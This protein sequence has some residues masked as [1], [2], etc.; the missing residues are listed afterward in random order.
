MAF[1]GLGSLVTFLIFNLRSQLRS[2]IVGVVGRFEF[3]L[4][5]HS[6]EEFLGMR[7]DLSSVSGSNQF[8]YFFPVFAVNL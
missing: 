6:E 3:K 7:S 5:F 8:L 2:G 1:L 4:F